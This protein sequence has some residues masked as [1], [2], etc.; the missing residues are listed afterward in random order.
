MPKEI[1]IKFSDDDADELIEL[2]R[3]LFDQI[4]NSS[5]DD[6]EDDSGGDQDDQ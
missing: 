1:I 6:D 4:N 2:L 3:D 5:V